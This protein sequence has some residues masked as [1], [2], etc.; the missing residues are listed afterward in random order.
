M[1]NPWMLPTLQ[2]NAT[3]MRSLSSDELFDSLFSTLEIRLRPAEYE[4]LF[5]T[6]LYNE[7]FLYSSYFAS[8]HSAKIVPR[9]D[10]KFIVMRD[11]ALPDG[12]VKVVGKKAYP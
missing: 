8:L 11:S 3:Y 2:F 12:M 10:H 5:C 7:C 9:Q 1:K 4:I 6:Y